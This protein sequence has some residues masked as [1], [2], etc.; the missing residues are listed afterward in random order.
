MTIKINGIEIPEP[1]RIMPNHD[2]YFWVV[3][4]AGVCKVRM[5]YHYYVEAFKNGALHKTKEAAQIH[6]DAIWSP[7]RIKGICK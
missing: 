4:S 1:L 3:S 6:Y 2:D 5:T 7:T